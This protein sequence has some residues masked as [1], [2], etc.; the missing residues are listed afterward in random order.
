MV[1]GTSFSN[2]ILDPQQKEVTLGVGKRDEVG[3]VTAVP[4]MS[5]MIPSFLPYLLFTSVD[6]VETTRSLGV[7]VCGVVVSGEDGRWDS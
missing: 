4:V 6:E 1:P 5:T 2:G 3:W 7:K